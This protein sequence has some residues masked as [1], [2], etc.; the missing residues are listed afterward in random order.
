MEFRTKV[1]L[2]VGQ[3]EIDHASRLMLWGSCFS[4]HIGS[5]LSAYKFNCDVNPYGILYNPLSIARA[6]SEL[7]AEK[8]YTP[9]DLICHNGEWHSLMHHGSFSSSAPEECLESINGRCREAGKHLAEAD[10]LLFTW[11]TARVYEWNA[12]GQVVGNCHKLPEKL[13]TRRLLDPAE[14]VARYEE[15]LGELH[16]KRPSLQV[17]FTVSPIRHARDGMHGNQVS[18]AVL[19]LA[20]EQLCERLP[21]CHYF[22]AYEILMDELRDYRFYADDMLHPSSVAV[23]YVWECFTATCFSSSARQVM[24]AWEEIRRGLAH[25]PFHA[26]GEAYQRFLRQILLKIEQLK[27]KFPYLDT[28]N[29]EQICQKRLKR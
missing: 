13:F 10:W 4:E 12:D 22:P 14:I 17:L 16:E 27:E 26:E 7:M 5:R 2:P 18:K 3:W 20:A 1:E 24:K 11:G 21:Y 9:D 25:R 15:L 19:L 29:E 6:L 8:V 23:D 28:Q